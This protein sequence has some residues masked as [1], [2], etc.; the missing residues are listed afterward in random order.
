M[1]DV[2]KSPSSGEAAEAAAALGRLP[3]YS[4]ASS[5]VLT[6]WSEWSRCRDDKE[7]EPAKLF[8]EDEES[9]GGNTNSYA[10]AQWQVRVRGVEK[11]PFFGDTCPEQ[12]ELKICEG[13]ATATN[14]ERAVVESPEHVDLETQ[15]DG[16]REMAVTGGAGKVGDEDAQMEAFRTKRL[17][18]VERQLEQ[19]DAAQVDRV[20]AQLRAFLEGVKQHVSVDCVLGP[21]SPWTECK[22]P[23][24][25]LRTRLRKSRRRRPAFFRASFLAKEVAA[26]GAGDT[27]QAEEKKGET[28]EKKIMGV[29]VRSRPVL[30]NEV[31][32]RGLGCSRAAVEEKETCDATTA[33][34]EQAAQAVRRSR[35]EQKRRRRRLKSFSR[36][37]VSRT[38]EETVLHKISVGGKNQSVRNAAMGD[39][40][41]AKET[42]GQLSNAGLRQ[43]EASAEAVTFAPTAGLGVSGTSFNIDSIA[44]SSDGGP[45]SESEQQMAGSLTLPASSGEGTSLTSPPGGLSRSSDASPVKD[46]VDS[47][48]SPAVTASQLQYRSERE[49]RAHLRGPNGAEVDVGAAAAAA[50][51]PKGLSSLETKG[52]EVGE[53]GTDAFGTG[54]IEPAG[55]QI[56]VVAFGLVAVSGVLLACTLVF[57]LIGCSKKVRRLLAVGDGAP[58]APAKEEEDLSEKLL[59]VQ[60]VRW[61]LTGLFAL[62]SPDGNQV[63]DVQGQ[64]L[65]VTSCLSSGAPGSPPRGTPLSTSVG[66]RIF[67]TRE[68]NLVGE[69]GE[70]LPVEV[71]PMELRPGYIPLPTVRQLAATYVTRP[72]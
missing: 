15:R 52:E 67:R 4:C 63:Y 26:D 12:A 9:V 69:W 25:E 32:G 16:L 51:L 43:E 44:T 8:S 24:D 57:L 41:E 31:T 19:V 33:C 58:V 64:Q 35:E 45:N 22:C 55:E 6:P 1:E 72:G 46:Q 66:E 28:A 30:Q 37:S 21:F 71:L 47:G 65:I 5:C 36:T 7:E 27:G 48:G 10:G 34:T 23:V 59:S 39:G 14:L 42:K 29:R 18:A 60:S 40:K 61:P 3:P 56:G 70:S 62:V 20:R 68:G 17:E 38:Q 53:G 13:S 54:S 49:I 50:K 2:L 11:A